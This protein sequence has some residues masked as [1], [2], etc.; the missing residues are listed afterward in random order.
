MLHVIICVINC[1][2]VAKQRGAEIVRD[3]WEEDDGGGVVRF[4]QIRTASK[5][6]Y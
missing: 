4:A 1:T 6:K 5:R 2:Q 3:I